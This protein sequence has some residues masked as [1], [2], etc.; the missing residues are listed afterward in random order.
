M[1]LFGVIDGTMGRQD[2]AFVGFLPPFD[3]AIRPHET[4][5]QRVL[6]MSFSLVSICN[7]ALGQCG[8]TK[9]IHSLEFSGSQQVSNEARLCALYFELAFR[10]A[11][12]GHA[13]KC[14]MTQADISGALTTPPAAGFRYAYSLP[15]NYIGS[16][17]VLEDIEWAKVGRTVQTDATQVHIEYV[18]YTLNTDLYDDLFVEALMMRLAAHLAP[19]L[20]GEG[21]KQIR[22]GLLAWHERVS[23]PQAR[24]ADALEESTVSGESSTWRNSRL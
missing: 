21:G 16:L 7:M 11:A 23:L 5:I 3:L 19:A 22:E 8:V 4:D 17:R 12:R 15:A 18:Q 20:C 1:R 13:W 24:L 9:Q 6:E 2:R 10:A 14:L